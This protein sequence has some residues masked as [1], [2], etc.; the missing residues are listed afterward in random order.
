MASKETVTSE[1]LHSETFSTTD[2]RTSLEETR[3]EESLSSQT[4][5]SFRRRIKTPS[6][7]TST[8]ATKRKYHV[9]TT[10][11]KNIKKRYQEKKVK[12]KKILKITSHRPL[13][14]VPKNK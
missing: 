12:T 11:K 10:I 3:V 6:P 1:P 9:K 2:P 8:S 5:S 13:V 7:L 14:L 4:T